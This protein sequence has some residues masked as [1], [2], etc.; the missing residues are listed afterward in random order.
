VRYVHKNTTFQIPHTPDKKIA[1][2]K[3]NAVENICTRKKQKYSRL[4]AKFFFDQTHN[5]SISSFY[6]TRVI[7]PT[8]SQTPADQAT[9]TAD[10]TIQQLRRRR[11]REEKE[12]RDKPMIQVRARRCQCSTEN[13]CT[14]R[15]RVTIFHARSPLSPLLNLF[16]H[17]RVQGLRLK[18][19]MET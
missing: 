4:P 8:S 14:H 7:N 1:V 13:N 17:K 6:H 3:T 19:T 9:N 18:S 11:S 15:A 10:G 16:K 2:A 5:P 12:R